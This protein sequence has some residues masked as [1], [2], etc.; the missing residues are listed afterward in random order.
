MTFLAPLA[1]TSRMVSNPLGVST[2]A[3]FVVRRMRLRGSSSSHCG[4]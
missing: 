1:K 4:L 3:P 2:V